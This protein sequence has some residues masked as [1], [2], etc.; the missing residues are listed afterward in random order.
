[1]QYPLSDRRFNSGYFA[2][3]VPC[4]DS[5]MKFRVCVIFVVGRK[6]LPAHEI[7]SL[8]QANKF[9]Y[10]YCDTKSTNPQG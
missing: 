10:Y 8:R 5:G 1:M 7:L 6:S 4:R 3:A 9:N 2:I